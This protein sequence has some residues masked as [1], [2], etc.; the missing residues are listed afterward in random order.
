MSTQNIRQ[1][2][3]TLDKIENGSSK[4]TYQLL[5]SASKT[6]EVVETYQQ[7]DE[8]LGALARAPMGKIAAGALGAGALG[9]AG[10]ALYNK[11]SKGDDSSAPSTSS[12]DSTGVPP[13]SPDKGN[14][15]PEIKSVIAQPVDPKVSSKEDP[16]GM[17]PGDYKP[18]P[19]FVSITADLP[20]KSPG[21]LHGLLDSLE[22]GRGT[23]VN[24][25]KSWQFKQSTLAIG[26]GERSGRG[27]GLWMSMA[28]IAHASDDYSQHM[29]KLFAKFGYN[30]ESY[31]TG[32]VST[33]MGPAVITEDIGSKGGKKIIGL[34]TF[35]LFAFKANNTPGL[36]LIQCN[37]IGPMDDFTKGGRDLWI[38]LT[39][40]LRP[41]QGAEPLQPKQS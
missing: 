21:S 41:A 6:F 18:M 38:Q 39:S 34:S 10:A 12:S 28:G 20:L 13:G 37:F 9:A 3:E 2:V 17:K 7:L 14:A 32:T 29:K 11:F 31:R 22:Q 30:F 35:S 33:S 23:D 26:V 27:A 8:F 19:N 24:I 15:H 5:N 40:A 16:F 4:N 36:Q 1:L 25:V